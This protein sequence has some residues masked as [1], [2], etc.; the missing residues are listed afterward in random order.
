MNTLDQT[1][2]LNTI[3]ESLKKSY[4]YP[5]YRTLVSDLVAKN[6]ATGPD[7]SEAMAN[8]TMLNDKRMKRWDKTIKIT[9]DAKQKIADFKGDFTWVVLT[10]SWCGDA[11]HVVPAIQKVAE[12]NDNIDLKIVLR[13]ENEA[14]MDQFL[15]NGGKSIPKLIMLDNATGEVVGSYGPRPTEATAMVNDYKTKHGALTPEFKE[16]L[17]HWYNK[18]KGQAVVNDMLAVLSL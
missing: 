7:Q 4:T 1:P 15:T 5:E 8:Y 11:A 9:E 2:V 13:D 12:L 10:E 14:L 6:G 16:E 18:N 17:Q 3:T